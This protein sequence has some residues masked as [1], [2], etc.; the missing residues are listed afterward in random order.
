MTVELLQPTTHVYVEPVSH[1]E[2]AARDIRARFESL[3][4]SPV[5]TVYLSPNNSYMTVISPV[6]DINDDSFSKCEINE[7]HV[8]TSSRRPS[9]SSSFSM[10]AK[11]LKN[12]P[13]HIFNIKCKEI[14][15]AVTDDLCYEEDFQ[16]ILRMT[17]SN[18]DVKC[19]P[20]TDYSC[21]F[22]TL[23]G[24]HPAELDI[25]LTISVT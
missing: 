21:I 20:R 13:G 3:P 9:T 6:S 25:E 23:G 16:E 17:L 4:A 5:S 14:S 2:V 7:A 10:I 12:H 11:P 24:E 8:K 18:I 22:K 15:I 19:R 1:L